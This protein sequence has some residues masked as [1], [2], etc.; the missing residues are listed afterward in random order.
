MINILGHTANILYAFGFLIKD[1]L[2]LRL[3]MAL[4]LALEIIYSYYIAE[5]PLWTNI[6][7]CFIYLSVNGWQITFLLFERRPIILTNEERLLHEKIFFDFSLRDY[8][9]VLRA[10]NVEEFAPGT[11]LAEENMPLERLILLMNGDC[12]I[13]IQERRIARISD[14]TF[15]GEMGFLTD[16]PASAKVSTEV[17]CKCLVWDKSH[18]K[19]LMKS[20]PA[21]NV[22]MQAIFT[23]DIITKLKKQNREVLVKLCSI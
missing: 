23:S 9:K 1:V 7:W 4:A 8:L 2:G 12:G 22:C 13:D 14:F 15:I 10:G 6:I 18:L 20:D 11:I 21:M 5:I 3:V 17:P 19:S 16:E